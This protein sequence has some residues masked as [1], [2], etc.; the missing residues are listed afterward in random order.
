MGMNYKVYGYV[1]INSTDKNRDE[2]VNTILNWASNNY[3]HIELYKDELGMKHHSQMLEDIL[4]KLQ[5]GDVFVITDL[6]QLGRFWSY[7][8]NIYMQLIKKKVVIIVIDCPTLLAN[9][10]EMTTNIKTR[11]MLNNLMLDNIRCYI[12]K[13][14]KRR[15]KRVVEDKR[16]R[17]QIGIN[18]KNKLSPLKINKIRTLSLA[19]MTK[20][21]IAE[22][23]GVSMTTVFDVLRK[24][25]LQNESIENEDT[26]I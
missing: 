6:I 9:Y 3:E 21:K 15:N 16:V 11:D 5:S 13:E 2:K 19:G 10:G 14:H 26:E 4:N 8:E 23:V 7:V 20:S 1:R 25:R 17:K 12:K 18:Y 24:Y 22:I